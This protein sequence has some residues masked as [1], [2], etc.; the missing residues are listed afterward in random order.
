LKLDNP[1]DVILLR[2]NHE[3]AGTNA[4]Y[5][6]YD[7]LDKDD[8]LF[9]LVNRTF[10]KMPIAAVLNGKV[11]CVHGGI[12]DST[13]PD[14][15]EKE[16][17][18]SFLWND[19]QE[20]NGLKESPVRLAAQVFGPDICK[21]F[22]KS[23]E[24]DMIIRAHSE[25][26]AGYKWWFDGKLLSIFSTPDYCGSKNRGAFVFVE[27][28]E[29]KLID[30]ELKTFVFG[31]TE[32]TSYSLLDIVSHNSD[33]F[34]FYDLNSDST[35]SLNFDV[36]ANSIIDKSVIHGN[37]EPRLKGA[38]VIDQY[39]FIEP[40]VIEKIILECRLIETSDDLYAL[41]EKHPHVWEQLLVD[42]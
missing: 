41:L 32:D 27:Y 37:T 16:E 26:E 36:K 4:Y 25:L 13:K 29:W 6:L 18:H 35:I 23:N 30:E 12:D 40:N 28:D 3:T 2:G 39:S 21:S 33:K 10:E 34:E 11:F 24:L 38:M 22:L 9:T 14:Q 1:D 31:R 5:G 42:V 17:C 15:I 8:K 7:D 20:E 19:P